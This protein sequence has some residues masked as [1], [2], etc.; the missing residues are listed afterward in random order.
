M[1]ALPLAPGALH[2]PL[3]P[4]PPALSTPTPAPTRQNAGINRAIM[5]FILGCMGVRVFIEGVPDGDSVK[6]SSEL[7]LHTSSFA[8][9]RWPCG[10]RTLKTGNRA[11]GSCWQPDAAFTV[12]APSAPPGF[13]IFEM[14]DTLTMYLA[15]NVHEEALLVHHTLGI[16]LYVLTL[17]TQSYMY[18][19][20]V[21]LM[22]VCVCVCVCLLS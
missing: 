12:V 18:L 6:G 13:F 1:G 5:G 11:G 19:A 7:L 14:R 10:K 2:R 15:H 16:F 4:G 9:G 22:Q 8:L 20:C 17:S 21:V 3:L